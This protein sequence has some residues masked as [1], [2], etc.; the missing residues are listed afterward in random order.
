MLPA[1]FYDG[2]GS[3][4]HPVGLLVVGDE[5]TVT[6]DNLQLRFP[7][8][9]IRVT[10]RLGSGP[11]RI[12][13]PDGSYCEVRDLE[14]LDELLAM[15]DHRDGL[16]D[17]LQRHWRIALLATLSFIAVM[18]SAYLWGLPVAAAFTARHLPDSVG[19][20]LAVQT[21]KALDG[22]FFKPSQLPEERRKQI[23][24]EF[25]AL[26]CPYRD[27]PSSMLEFRV[28]EALGAN[29]LT[30]PDGTIVLL[31]GLVKA[32]DNDPQILAVLAHEMGHAG[33]RHPLQLLLQGSAVAAF[34]GLYIGDVSGMLATTPTILIQARYS[35]NLEQ[36][37]DDFAARL[38]KANGLSPSLLAEALEKLAA[39]HHDTKVGS[40]LSS[41]PATDERIRR[42]RQ[43]AAD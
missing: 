22:G 26:R 13:F 14:R 5:L 27:C 40:Y 32:M 18:V 17:R 1:F 16:V 43:Q 3:R 19:Q 9:R 8:R 7:V 28:S 25:R 4:L 24:A 6:G 23:Q 31:D 29:A 37:A 42:L 36:D 35:R 39:R 2:R 33:A 20:Q 30:L 41:H 11:R 34:W 15:T 21:L 38:L 10:E 12:E